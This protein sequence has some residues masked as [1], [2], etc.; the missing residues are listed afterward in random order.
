VSESV[1]FFV[2]GHETGCFSVDESSKALGALAVAQ[3]D[4]PSLSAPKERSSFEPSVAA[5]PKTPPAREYWPR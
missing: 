4:I 1:G 5:L 3:R 2:N